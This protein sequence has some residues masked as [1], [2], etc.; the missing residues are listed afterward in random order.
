MLQIELVYVTK[1]KTTVH[2]SVNV[3]E[4]ATVLEVIKQSGI[5]ETHPEILGLPVGIF[6]KQVALDT[7]VKQ[8]D[9]IEFYRPLIQDP[10]EKRRIKARS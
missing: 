8:G 4:G 5:E 7:V 1:D 9:R 10:K 2:L 6:S 3:Q